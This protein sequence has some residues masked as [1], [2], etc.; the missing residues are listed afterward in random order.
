MRVLF[1]C[2]NSFEKTAGG[3]VE[4]LHYLPPALRALGIEILY[5]AMGNE[6]D[7]TLQGPHLLPNGVPAYSG[8][9]IKPG[10]FVA[11]NKLTALEQL[12]RSEK[13]DLVHAQG[14]YRSGFVARKLFQKMQIPYVVMS[15]G[16]VVTTNSSRMQRGSVQRRCQHILRDATGVIHL[17]PMMA[18][19]SHALCDARQ[20]SVVIGNGIDLQSFAGLD[21][22]EQDYMLAIG[23][24]EREKGFHVLVDVYAA[25]RQ[26]D[27][28]TSLVIAGTGSQAQALQTQ[29][30]A[31]GLTVITELP[32][33]SAIPPASIVFTGYVKGEVK[34]QLISQ[35]KLMLFPTQPA[36]WDEPFGIVQIEAMAAGK[37]LVASDSPVTRYLQT[38]GLQ[39][40]LV[41]ADD[42]A[43]WTAQI[44]EL[45]FDPALRKTAGD[46]NLQHV[47]QFDWQ[48]IAVQYRD[49]YRNILI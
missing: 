43:G 24:L 49:F 33:L 42:I 10:W 20:K 36:Q 19:A 4:Y 40:S 17:T 41:R 35:C 1:L 44:G 11:R 18:E 3:V 7:D 16:D 28:R 5:Y 13:I 25:L 14:T 27:V 15:H 37:A 23:R 47:D 48:P 2:R 9:V 45:L 46:M 30:R 34:C 39:A 26:Q 6:L 22:S 12:C 38:K 32:A 29:A 8:P 31:L 21:T